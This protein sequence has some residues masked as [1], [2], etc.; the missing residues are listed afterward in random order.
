MQTR[1]PCSAEKDNC[2]FL[3]SNSS[4]PQGR[5]NPPIRGSIVKVG[6]AN[7]DT[8]MGQLRSQS[9]YKGFNSRLWTTSLCQDILVSIPL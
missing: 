4:F 5:I 9:P 3:I 7:A 1:F 6:Y 8:P 2:S